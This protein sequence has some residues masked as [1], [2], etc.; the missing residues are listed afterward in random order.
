MR[1]HSDLSGLLEAVTS[2]REC[3][4]DKEH[5]LSSLHRLR[6]VPAPLK[7]ILVMT[8]RYEEL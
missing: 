1:D 5:F 8:S 6:M 7:D 4:S 3:L 2:A